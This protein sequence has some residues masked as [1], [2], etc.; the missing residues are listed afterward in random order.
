VSVE[1][2]AV[3]LAVLLGEFDTAEKFHQAYFV[4]IH[5]FHDQPDQNFNDSGLIVILQ[6][7]AVVYKGRN[8]YLL[9]M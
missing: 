7:L 8:K 1:L 6:A 5:S 9:I 3:A 2:F 4:F